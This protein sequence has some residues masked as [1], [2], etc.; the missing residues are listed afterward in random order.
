MRSFNGISLLTTLSNVIFASAVIWLA[1]WS[2]RSLIVLPPVIIALHIIYTGYQR[3]QQD[4]DAWRMLDA[5]NGDLNRGDEEQVVRAALTWAERMFRTSGASLWLRGEAAAGA[6]E[7]S[8]A[9][10]LWRRELGEVSHAQRTSP[11][12]LVSGAREVLKVR[13][14]MIGMLD[15][16]LPA[17]GS[18]TERERHLFTAF[19]DAVSSHLVNARLLSRQVHEATHDGLTGLAKPHA[20]APPLSPPSSSRPGGQVVALLPAARPR[21]VQ[22]GQRHARARGRRRAAPAGRRA[23]V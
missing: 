9:W 17:S 20:A 3:V 14:G 12:Q 23:S 15:I 7:S 1:W 13:E 16:A 5:A 19:A 11:T 18:L 22:A 6:P 8:D 2:P 10:A 21:P 4:R